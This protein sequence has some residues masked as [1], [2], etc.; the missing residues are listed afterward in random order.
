MSA[1][2]DHSHHVKFNLQEE[3][4]KNHHENLEIVKV[5]HYKYDINLGYLKI[6]H[7]Y[8]VVFNLKLGNSYEDV[9]F[10]DDLSSP[11]VSL[12]ELKKKGELSN[13]EFEMSFVFYASK[14]KHDKETAFLRLDND[15]KKILE[16]NFEAKVLGA[17]QGTPLLR[18]GITILPN[19]TNHLNSSSNQKLHFNI[20]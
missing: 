2:I 11:Q 15:E 20:N 13:C 3:E 6:D 5:D 1:G 7:Y 17:H 4:I 12:K 14:E 9:K 16:I 8:K 18:N 10:I 19:H